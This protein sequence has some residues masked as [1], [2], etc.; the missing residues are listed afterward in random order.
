[1]KSDQPLETLD[2]LP[3][4]EGL[5]FAAGTEGL[6]D[7]QIA[8]VFALRT[9]Q[10]R[11]ACERLFERQT[12]EQR[13]FRVVR[14]AD[15]WQLVTHPELTPYLRELALAPTP[16][17]LSNAALEVL[18]IIAYKQ[19][20]TRSQIEEIRGVKCEKP[21]GTL[22]ARGLIEEVGRAEGPGKPYLYGTTKEFMDYF[23]IPSVNELPPIPISE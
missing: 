4:L 20:I 23:G 6:T 18:A 13:M 11:Y 15:T 5:L 21:L 8:S 14:M 9:D 1:M 19:P 2:W 12:Q 16:A 17:T 3:A 10:V 22:M 7:R